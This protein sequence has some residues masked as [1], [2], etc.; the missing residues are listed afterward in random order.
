LFSLTT[1]YGCTM[2]DL[3][4]RLLRASPPD[5]GATDELW[6]R[7][8]D[9]G[10]E[11][12]FTTLL[13]WY[14]LPVYRR[15]WGFLRDHASAEDAF[16]SAVGKLH[17]HRS[18]LGSFDVALRWWMTAVL[19][20]SRMIVRSRR[21][22]L[23]RERR[24]AVPESTNPD[25]RERDE[26]LRQALAALP[27]Q[28]RE[29]VALVYFDGLTRLA[30]AAVLG[31]HR[32][33]LSKYLDAALARLRKALVAVG[34]V[35]VPAAVEAALVPHPVVPSADTLLRLAA[36]RAVVPGRRAFRH[37]LLAVG[38]VAG[39]GIG[40]GA[41]FAGRPANPEAARLDPLPA[42]DPQVEV[43]ESVP[44][45]NLRVFRVEVL[46][47]QLATLKGLAR[48]DGE[49]ELETV[50]A[51]DTRLNCK[52][53]IR[54]R[55]EGS[56]G[57]VSKLAM[58][59]NTLDHRTEFSFNMSGHGAS[60][61]ID[62]KRPIVLWRNHFTGK[63][64]VLKVPALEEVG[65]AFARLPRDDRNAAEW[66]EHLRRAEAAVLP[67]DGTW[68][69]SGDPTRP[70]LFTLNRETLTVHV[71]RGNVQGL[72]TIFGTLRYDPG[73][74]VSGL[75]IPYSHARVSDDGQTVRFLGRDEWWSHEPGAG[76]GK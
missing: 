55:V 50:G 41:W 2:R 1:Q 31:V 73:G 4:V 48:G 70:V 28:Q 21:R 20:E 5:P 35:A 3:L 49:V 63:E 75:P 26:T 57:W 11:A 30:A 22:I 76:P 52:Y 62:P 24:G 9:H 34:T 71:L 10:D 51:T 25:D 17:R 42:A 47:R 64:V 37:V 23:A 38:L 58:E 69:E 44:A 27:A 15:A 53:L 33:T 39:G 14:G 16:Q 18:R 54:H 43:V 68:Y 40:V 59:H 12:A 36:V 72:F 56:P 60:Q 19:N 67:F 32:D 6:A 46:P 45:R 61:R 29:A 74:W 13:G 66:H 7:Y 8:R 65:A